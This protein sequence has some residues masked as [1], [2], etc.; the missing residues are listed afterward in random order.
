MSFNKSGNKMLPHQILKI[1]LA[2]IILSIISSCKKETITDPE[3]N[4]SDFS[5]ER[6]VSINGYS[7]DAMEPF[8]SKDDGYMF[9]NNHQ[10]VNSKDIYYAEKID[11]TTFLFKGEVQGVNTEFVDGN[12]TMDANNNFYFISTRDLDSGIKT[13]FS[14]IFNNGTVSNLHKINGTVNIPTPYWINMGV[15][16][17]TD[18]KTLFTSNAKFNIGDNFPNEGNIRFA[19]KTNDEYN[20]PSNEADILI[21]IN[22]DQ[23]IQYAGET[24]I[25]ELEIFYSQ[26]TLSDPPIFKL[27][28][29]NRS[30]LDEVFSIPQ[31]ITEPF[32][33]NPNAFVEGPSLSADSKRLYYHKLENEVFSIFMLSR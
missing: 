29:S 15:E 16:I 12:P 21:N 7:S 32:K 31:E 8:I 5:N 33:D 14:G 28:Y 22:N 4:N 11:D 1:I 18:N 25:D 19:V 27:F 24:S 2:I 3:T 9:F 6:K 26:V 13:I 10:G 17:S 20:I 30:K 23:S